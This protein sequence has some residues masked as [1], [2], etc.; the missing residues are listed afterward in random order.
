MKNKTLDLKKGDTP[1]RASEALVIESAKVGNVCNE[2]KISKNSW[3][4]SI[5]PKNI[6]NASAPLMLFERLFVEVRRRIRKMCAFTTRS[7]CKRIFY[8]VFKRMNDQ[9]TLHHST[10]L[11][12][13]ID[14]TFVDESA[15]TGN[16][17]VRHD[18]GLAFG[19]C[20]R[21]GRP[22]STRGKT[23][24]TTVPFFLSASMLRVAPMV[25]AR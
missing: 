23:H 2:P 22:L 25:L 5:V 13:T 3:P 20:R 6:G 7:S 14:A 19:E 21:M 16:H 11:H 1:V 17:T 9:W 4:S 10:L 8:S 18:S 12:R 24:V 15:K